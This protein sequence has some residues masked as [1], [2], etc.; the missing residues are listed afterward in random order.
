MYEYERNMHVLLV[1]YVK[2]Y[3]LTLMLQ[4][5]N[6]SNRIFQR[7]YNVNLAKHFWELEYLTLYTLLF[8]LLFD[9]NIHDIFQ[10]LSNLKS[11]ILFFHVS[12]VFTLFIEILFNFGQ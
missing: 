12:Y 10:D 9:I 5:Y 4:I 2:L 6:F 11:L 7:I 8:S 1:Y 3:V